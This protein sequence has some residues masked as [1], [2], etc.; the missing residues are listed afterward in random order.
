MSDIDTYSVVAVEDDED[1]SMASVRNN[2]IGG[3]YEQKLGGYI[4]SS[5]HII[6][7]KDIL[8]VSE[9]EGWQESVGMKILCDL[10]GAR[11]G[12]E[13]REREGSY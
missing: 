5:R 1:E 4:N 6:A 2:L 7:A 3:A 12:D 10:V 11:G 9:G 8:V 13:G